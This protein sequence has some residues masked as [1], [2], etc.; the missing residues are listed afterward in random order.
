MSLTRKSRTSW[1]VVV[2]LAGLAAAALLRL[3]V[4][5]HDESV[6]LS[7][8]QVI[9]DDAGAR[10]WHGTMMNRTDSQ[11]RAVAVTIRFLG[12]SGQPVG[13]A[14]GHASRLEPGEGIHIEA[15]LPAEAQTV[16][17]YSL[18]WQT[19]RNNVERQLGPWAPWEFG[20]VQY[21]PG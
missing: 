3:G 9:T 16:Q 7:R 13:Q 20:Y 11:Y 1:F 8:N 14:S 6:V 18:Q 17:V 5:N 21:S 2:V 12:E 19:G 10:T 4:A 15:Q